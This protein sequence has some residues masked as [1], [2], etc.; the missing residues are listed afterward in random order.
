[1]KVI[2]LDYD[3]VLNRIGNGHPTPVR[4]INGVMTMAEPELVYRLN[5]IVDRTDAELVL[6]SSW[7]HLPD[8]RQAMKASGIVKAF[9]DR[10]PSR[11]DHRKYGIEYQHLC[12]GHNIQDWL[13]EHPDVERYA[14]IDDCADMLR[15]QTPNFFRTNEQEGLTQE[16]ADA[17]ERH[18]SK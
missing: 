10:T 17:V 3:G 13:D 15:S 16:I 4:T 18:L 14:I 7:R 8:W 12:R 9:L 5:L 6:S 11:S 1:M 2:F